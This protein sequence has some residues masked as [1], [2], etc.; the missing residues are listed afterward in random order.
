MRGVTVASYALLLC[1]MSAVVAGAAAYAAPAAFYA[2][3]P[4]FAKL[5]ASAADF[6]KL[7]V[8]AS[9]A[10][11][12]WAGS[13]FSACLSGPAA[14][15]TY[16]AVN[17][18]Q[19]AI[20]AVVSFLIGD[21]TGGAFWTC[22]SVAYIAIAMCARPALKRLPDLATPHRSKRSS[23]AVRDDST[24]QFFNGTPSVATRRS[25][26]LASRRQ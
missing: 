22:V 17:I 15:A 3:T 16:C 6:A 19:L 4:V 24:A 1:G 20:L 7:R 10:L 13:Q 18:V 5:G 2:H 25:P 21:A 9:V 23:K 12:S 8:L 26:R 14:V 11:W